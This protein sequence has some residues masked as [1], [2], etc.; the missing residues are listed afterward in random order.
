MK[1]VYAIESPL[2][3]LYAEE[4]GGRVTALHLPGLPHPA[5]AGNPQT[6]LAAELG[7]YFAGKRKA[8]DVPISQGGPAFFQ[9]ALDA[10]RAIPYGATV[11][12]AELAASAGNPAA[13]RAAGQAMAR[14]PLP[15]LIPCH[16]VLYS[17]GK[18]Q[19]YA[20]GPKMKQFLLDLENRNK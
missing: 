14:N 16:R 7:E 20:G 3:I 9:K 10:A 11:T 8:F 13:V 15:I 5:P 2:G 12:Y 19:Q 4:E 18:R 17:H 6:N 1:S